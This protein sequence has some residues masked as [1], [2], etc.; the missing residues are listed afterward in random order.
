MSYQALVK[1][2]LESLEIRI[3]TSFSLDRGRAVT[4][5]IAFI[6]RENCAE[7]RLEDKGGHLELDIRPK[8]R[9]IPREEILSWRAIA[10]GVVQYIELKERWFLEYPSG[11]IMSRFNGITV[12]AH[13]N[14]LDITV[15]DDVVGAFIVNV[16][17]ER[18]P[19]Q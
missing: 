1:I 16:I 4:P 2:A 5:A 6:G 13:D 15:D 17:A 11:K 14:M 19:G 18:N 8:L 3:P 12:T 7:L 10:S 9:S